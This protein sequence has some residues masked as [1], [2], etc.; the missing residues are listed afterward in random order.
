MKKEA[1]LI[2]SLA[3][4]LEMIV[5][6]DEGEWRTYTVVDGLA[7]P[8]VTAIFQD[9]KSS[10][11]F[12]TGGGISR[13]DGKNFQSFSGKDG[14][15]NDHIRQIL[16]DK[17]GHLWLIFHG[18]HSPV[19]RYDGKTFLRMTE[20]D[21]LA[22]GFSNV[23]LK[24]GN[25]D[26]W[27]ANAHG[28]TKFDGKEFQPFGIGEF[29][30][31]INAKDRED[32]QIHAILESQSGDIWLGGGY[33]YERKLPAFVIRYDRSKFHHFPL[34]SFP[35][36]SGIYAIA[37][38]KA[39]NL[40]FGG[41]YVLCKYDGKNFERFE[42]EVIIENGEPVTLELGRLNTEV[43]KPGVFSI[44]YR[45]PL[46]LPERYSGYGAPTPLING[47][48]QS[49]DGSLYAIGDDSG[50][51]IAT[52]KIL[53]D[54]F[55]K[56]SQGRLW[57]NMG[58][59]LFLWD[60]DQLQ[61]FMSLKWDATREPLALDE[62]GQPYWF[63]G[64][65]VLKD[66]LGNLW[67]RN[68]RGVHHYNGK[69]FQTFT[70]D[71]GLGSDDVS[72]IF[73]DRD[74]KFWFAH[75]NGVTSF[76]PV[77]A[78]QN[79]TTRG[80]LGSDRVNLIYEDKQGFVWFSVRGGIARYDGERL[81]YFSEKQMGAR[82]DMRGAILG[83]IDDGRDGVWFIGDSTSEIFR[84]KN[85]QF[86]H[87]SVYGS[88]S[89][90]SR[91][92]PRFL[93][94]SEG[95]LWF[96]FAV[97][98]PI[99]RCDGDG[100]ESLTEDGWKAVPRGIFIGG[101][102]IADFYL[103]S[104]G[105]IWFSTRN[106]GIKRYDGVSLKTA[107]TIVDGLGSN[108]VQK[109][110]EDR[111]GDL[112][113]ISSIEAL[114]GD[115]GY[116]MHINRYD[117]NSIQNFPVSPLG[118]THGVV[119]HQDT[120][121][122]LW[123]IG[124]PSGIWR[125]DGTDFDQILA[126]DEPVV[127]NLREGLR[128]SIVDG[129]GNLWLATRNGAVK[130]DGEQFHT[131]TTEDGFLTNDIRDVHED[132]QGNIWFATWGGGVVRYDGEAFQCITT[133]QGLVHNN[134]RSIFQDSRGYLWF[135]TNGGITKYV[136]KGT[137]RPP[138]IELTKVIAD[139]VYTEFW[140]EMQFP[141]NV[142]HLVFE[143]KGSSLQ[144]AKLLYSY[145]LA[146]HDRDWS[147]PSTEQWIEY[148][149]L[150][151]DRYVFWVKALREDLDYSNPPASISFSI[152][153]NPPFY[154]RVGFIIGAILALSITGG[155]LLCVTIILGVHRW[156]SSRAEK[157]RLQNEMKDAHS[158][159]LS[160]LP[161][162]A[163]IVSGFDMAGSSQPA[164][165]V[166]GDFF[167]YLS[168]RD[169]K[170]GIAIADVSGKGLRGAMNATLT[171]GMLSVEAEKVGGSCSRILSALNADLYPHLEKHM[172]VALRLVSIDGNEGKLQWANAAQP[173]PLVKRGDKILDFGGDGGLPLGIMPD[174]TY[175][176]QEL[177]LQSGNTVIFYTD[178]IIEAQNESEEMYGTERLE[179]VVMNMS[180]T[181]NAEGIIE[182][183]LQDVAGFVGD[184]EQYDDMT[185]VVVKR[186]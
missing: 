119:I 49:S 164:R 44:T 23:M 48:F 130:Y 7:S 141:A 41:R 29:Q 113:F 71:D 135:A 20:Q 134:V 60:G 151:P 61:H 90:G 118:D 144:G 98:D 157:L 59:F 105:N 159:Q 54:S 17:K 169:G 75:D 56:D 146:G 161:E 148:K 93:S 88:A 74:G 21:D 185:V 57:F 94:D 9:S 145:K 36:S 91:A 83:I 67:F 107:F 13:L 6:A 120:R 150:E 131:Y 35:P 79:F 186:L 92:G 128:D 78:I 104:K 106:E 34:A 165:E 52:V 121:G 162:S 32:A 4:L 100:F 43:R 26:L 173:Y 76:D 109:I 127:A 124:G 168:L 122:I 178:G 27:F 171:S 142:R 1:W 37:E 180:S 181:V 16:E 149:G 2:F 30:D 116:V 184:T 176:D 158:M 114:R 156:R 19:I 62:K 112:W 147:Q 3:F 154:T 115:I 42:K 126:Q 18:E 152:D 68:A 155:G 58:G 111:D 125:Y 65:A 167:D 137:H 84:Y 101:T 183:I 33:K 11:W 15:P 45:K 72:T 166:G 170:I 175:S 87:Y 129:E 69:G 153:R 55:L 86:R 8:N 38:D 47:R 103:D 14:L 81:Q 53:L 89:G 172:F 132:R 10:M 160:L 82:E 117:G 95:N 139:E 25:G 63:P 123:F 77:P 28:L 12:G 22:G 179:Q 66:Q 46:I 138:R 97:T 177:E 143:Y 163:P 70:V 40:L 64:Q 85:E 140:K 39:G 110:F 99:I 73:E 174:V 5:L 51:A 31:F 102:P 80:A 96:G 108:D 133:K 136:P 182:T 24:D 50:N